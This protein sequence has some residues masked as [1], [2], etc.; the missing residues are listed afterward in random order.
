MT[1]PPT[2]D[3]FAMLFDHDDH[4]VEP[5]PQTGPAMPPGVRLETWRTNLPPAQ[6]RGS[7]LR[8]GPSR[9]ELAEQARQRQLAILAQPMFQSKRILVGNIVGKAGKSTLT[10]L[11]AG[12]FAHWSGRGVVVVENSPTGMLRNRLEV[13]PNPIHDMDELAAALPFLRQ[14]QDATVILQNMF[15]VKQHQGQ[16]SVILGRQEDTVNDGTGQLICKQATLPRGDVAEILQLAGLAYSFVLIDSG[17]NCA[18]EAWWGSVDKTDL[19]VLATTWGG[20]ELD[21]AM[22]ILHTLHDTGERRLAASA[23]MVATQPPG[24]PVNQANKVGITNWCRQYGIPVWEIPPD[25]AIAD[26]AK[27]ILWDTLNPTTRESLLG[28][29]A[30]VKERLHATDTPYLHGM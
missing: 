25:P 28:L 23:I 17:N 27:P 16:F 19:L 12:G 15:A 29:C 14:R 6:P 11:L 8:R 3:V 26:R 1:Q 30:L 21:G 24:A 2:S 18:D 7:L 20:S 22:R 4:T 9:K 5:E 10:C 13:V